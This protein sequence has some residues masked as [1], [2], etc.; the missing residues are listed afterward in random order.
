MKHRCD[1]CEAEHAL[2]ALAPIEDLTERGWTPGWPAPSGQCPGCGG[3]CYPTRPVYVDPDVESL[4]D[5]VA[6]ALAQPEAAPLA[7]LHTRVERFVVQ[8]RR[9]RRAS[10]AWPTP[11]LAET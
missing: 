9:D 6:T 3:L 8:Y 7:N 4:L 11:E 1:D 2:S 5:E 10:L